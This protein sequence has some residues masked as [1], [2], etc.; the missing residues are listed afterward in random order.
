LTIR[1]G[2]GH[3]PKARHRLPAAQWFARYTAK[4]TCN[5]CHKRSIPGRNSKRCIRGR[6]VLDVFRA[7]VLYHE[8]MAV[9]WA[10]KVEWEQIQSAFGDS[11]E[12]GEL[13]KLIL[14]GE[15]VWGDLIGYVMH[16]GTIYEGT[17]AVAGW[18]VDALESKRLN[19]RLIPVGKVF[20]S[21]AVLSERAIAFSVLSSMAEDARDA[22]RSTSTPERYA[23]L[24]ALVLEA[25]RPGIPLYET[26]AKDPDDQINQ[27]G[28]T[29]LDALAGGSLAGIDRQ[30]L[31]SVRKKLGMPLPPD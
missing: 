4:W 26:G 14:E 16:Q 18:L 10:S 6:A 19:T 20:G 15:D 30:Y 3:R 27:A 5:A 8:S 24:A 1:A 2:S 25:L 13:L 21:S 22:L 11:R 7:R 12:L 29:L 28:A 23:A 31:R 9:Q 17:I